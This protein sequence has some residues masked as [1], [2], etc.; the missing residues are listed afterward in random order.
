MPRPPE[1][2]IPDPFILPNIVSAVQVSGHAGVKP[3]ARAVVGPAVPRRIAVMVPVR[4]GKRPVVVIITLA[5][6]Q[7]ITCSTRVPAHC[8]PVAHSFTCHPELRVLGVLHLPFKVLQLHPQHHVSVP[9]QEVDQVVAQPELPSVQL[10]EARSVLSP[11]A[12]ET[13]AP[14][15]AALQERP[16]SSTQLH[17]AGDR[18]APAAEVR[19]YQ[20]HSAPGLSPEQVVGAVSHYRGNYRTKDGTE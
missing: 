13:Y 17:V 12:V 11:G 4:G 8:Q 14:V 16:S 2:P 19:G 5:E 10:P 20:V 15:L 7:S 1:N 3:P 9:G 6:A 18:E